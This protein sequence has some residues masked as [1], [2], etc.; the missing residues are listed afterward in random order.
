MPRQETLSAM[1]SEET[2]FL[3][4]AREKHAANVNWLEFEEFAFGP[5]SPIFARKR[6]HQNVLDHPLYITLKNL[7]LDLG[8]RQGQV[9]A[10][11]VS[12]V[13]DAPRRETTGR[14]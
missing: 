2:A 1:T 10:P 4:R 12:K 7:W 6:S 3:A 9:A 8:A 14:R 11:T 13:A 5:R